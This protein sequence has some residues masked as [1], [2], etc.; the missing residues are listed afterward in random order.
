MKKTYEKAYFRDIN[1]RKHK[2]YTVR[3]MGPG[4]G[5]MVVDILTNTVVNADFATRENAHKWMNEN[6]AP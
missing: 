2:Q 5:Y 4:R 1:G 6:H 3:S